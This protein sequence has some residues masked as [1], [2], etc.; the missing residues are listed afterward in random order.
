MAMICL[1]RYRTEF[2]LIFHIYQDPC[3]IKSHPNIPSGPEK[4]CS[5]E[6]MGG[7]PQK[8]EKH[9]SNP[10]NSLSPLYKND[11][12]AK[13]LY[14]FLVLFTRKHNFSQAAGKRVSGFLGCLV[15]LLFGFFSL[16]L[17][18]IRLRQHAVCHA[19]PQHVAAPFRLLGCRPSALECL[20]ANDV[21]EE[22]AA[23]DAKRDGGSEHIAS[24]LGA[25]HGGV[26]VLL[27]LVELL[28]GIRHQGR[29]DVVP[30]SPEIDVVVIGAVRL[31]LLDEIQGFLVVS[32]RRV[33]H[34]PEPIQA[35][36]QRN[37]LL[38]GF[39]SSAP[40]LMD[41]EAV[42]QKDI[43]GGLEAADAL[44]IYAL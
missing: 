10:L 24:D 31:K 21:F 43:D 17:H 3:C 18:L 30:G 27:L 26:Y 15:P 23:H 7:N 41:L 5:S 1:V 14:L 4:S 22:A 6:T 32:T 40:L 13:Q 34:D 36:K 2:F 9:Q 28:R 44:V 38:P 35:R 29:H 11:S 42:V 12:F 20:L 33:L 8:E 39:D 16:S 25:C 37:L 19:L